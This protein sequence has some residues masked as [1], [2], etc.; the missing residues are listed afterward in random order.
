MTRRSLA[1]L[2]FAA[3]L[4]A[5]AS[6]AAQDGLTRIGDNVY[7]YVGTRNASPSNSFGAN[8]GIVIGNDGIAVIDTLISSKEAKRFIKDI[9]AVSDKPIKYV[10]NTHEHLDH[11]FGNSE[12]ARLGATIV[13][14]ENCRK[15]MLESAEAVLA[16][17]KDYGLSEDDVK[18][19]R[20]AVPTLT[21]RGAMRID[22]GGRAVE[23]VDP[24]PSHTDGSILVSVVWPPD[25][26]ILFAGDVLFT[27]YHPYMGETGTFP[28]GSRC[29]TGYWKETTAWSRSC[30]DTGLSPARRTSLP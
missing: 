23:L 8:A 24:G 5:A 30:R 27:D 28:D 18:G 25:G 4:L 2:A 29:S 20:I 1:A 11:A 15:R 3:V 14:G 22:L 10:I 19:T 13:S 21:F 7:A 9:R 12:F 16:N 26:T 17:A 6:A